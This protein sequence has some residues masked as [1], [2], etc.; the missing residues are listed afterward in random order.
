VSLWDAKDIDYRF[1][2]RLPGGNVVDLMEALK[3]SIEGSMPAKGKASRGG[4]KR[5]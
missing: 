5:A 3:T 2:E 1:F 4:K